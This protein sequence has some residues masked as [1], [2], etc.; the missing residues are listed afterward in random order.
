M[1]KPGDDGLVNTID[2][3][4]IEEQVTPGLDNVLGSE[5]DVHTR[6]TD[7]KRQ[8]EITELDD[9]DG[10]TYDDLRQIRV[11]IKYK[12]GGAWRQYTLTTYISSF[13]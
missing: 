1:K 5:D 9:A 10:N 2:D 3:D 8:I 7:F 13:S 6:L 11:I 4:G 12:V